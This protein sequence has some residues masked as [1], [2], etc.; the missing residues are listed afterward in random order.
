[1]R[2]I[3]DIPGVKYTEGRLLPY[4]FPDVFREGGNP[5]AE[6]AQAWRQARRAMLRHPVDRIGYGGYPSLAARFPQFVRV[7]EKI[8]AEFREIHN[9]RGS[10]PQT[11][12][13][14]VAI[15]NYWGSLRTWQTHMI[16]HALAYRM[17]EPYVGI[18]EA[19]SG[20]PV[21]VAWL[22][23]E[24]V[25][26]DGIPQD[27]G[28]LI[29][30][31]TAGT[32]F[33]GGE[34]WGNPELVSLIRAWVADGGAFIGVGEPSAHLSGGRT[35]Q[36][37]DVLGVDQEA[38]FSLSSDKYWTT[39]PKPHFLTVGLD[40]VLDTGAG[41]RFVYALE[42]APTR[43]LRADGED[44]QL[45]VNR[46]G[47]GRSVYLSGLP[48]TPQNSR[49]LHRALLWGMG[50][51]DGDPAQRVAWLPDNPGVE[52]SFFPDSGN[53]ALVNNTA[54]A[55]HCTVPTAAGEILEVELQPSELRWIEQP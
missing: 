30:A 54:S 31:G 12:P 49:L 43:V 40:P 35:F 52:V 28:V 38:G 10:G 21:D 55:Q 24:D 44:V 19:L 27:V 51:A 7:A 37:A 5:A 33:S 29:N 18:I 39:D 53:C 36:L 2:M 6:A 8:A 41:A 16:A 42:G 9:R 14:R 3:A 32:A 50:M 20:L 34:I 45:A 23:F 4:F 17:T 15:L 1:M 46:Y 47:A 26:R 25:L 22:S 48:Y 13:K 11:L